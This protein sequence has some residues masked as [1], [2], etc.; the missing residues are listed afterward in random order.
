M[1]IFYL[2]IIDGEQKLFS[3]DQE[4]NGLTTIIEGI[5]YRVVGVPVQGESV[6]FGVIH[7]LPNAKMGFRLS[8]LVK[9]YEDQ[10]A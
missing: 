1:K 2:K 4:V 6:K 10:A 9:L 7:D 8:Q 3:V 5:E